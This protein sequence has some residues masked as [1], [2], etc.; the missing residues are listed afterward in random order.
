MPFF[1]G[2]D[3]FFFCFFFFF[4]RSSFLKKCVNKSGHGM[5]QICC[6]GIALFFY[7]F[8]LFVS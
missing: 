4:S 8:C 7:D 1:W 5:C 3:S 2:E 6:F